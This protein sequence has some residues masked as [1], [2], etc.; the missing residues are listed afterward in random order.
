MGGVLREGSQICLSRISL[1]F[2]LAFISMP[3][4]D[5]VITGAVHKLC[6]QKTGLKKINSPQG[7]VA[8][9]HTGIKTA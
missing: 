1:A 9:Y 4:L 2:D 3:F 7:F 6:S 5:H 8:F